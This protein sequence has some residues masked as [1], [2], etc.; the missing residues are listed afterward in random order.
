MNWK[1]EVEVEGK[2]S[3]NAIVFATQPEAEAYARDLFGRWFVCTGH[4]AV[5]VDTAENPVNYTW[6]ENG[7]VRVEGA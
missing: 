2:W 5:E 6:T 7:I 3:Q 1:P 4:R